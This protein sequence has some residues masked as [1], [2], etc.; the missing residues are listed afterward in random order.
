LSCKGERIERPKYTC[1]KEEEEKRRK[2]SKEKH[3]RE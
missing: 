1:E 2:D 3:M